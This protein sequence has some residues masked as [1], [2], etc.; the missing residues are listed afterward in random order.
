MSVCCDFDKN[1]V[2]LNSVLL[3][4]PFDLFL[5]G[6]PKSPTKVSLL[7]GE[8]SKGGVQASVLLEFSLTKLIL[9]ATYYS[10]E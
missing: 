7:V 10:Q 5:D 1:V 6:R 8:A 2:N 9:F 4:V 3:L